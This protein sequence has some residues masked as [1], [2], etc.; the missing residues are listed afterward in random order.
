MKDNDVSNDSK[1][2]T[3]GVP[4]LKE[5]IPLALQH[6]MAMIVGNMVPAFL[7]ASIVGLSH[8][9][10][11]MLVQVSMLS[12]AIGTFIQLYPLPFIGSYKIGANLPVI[13]GM[14]YVF[15]GAALSITTEYGLPA[16]LGGQLVASILGIFIG[17]FVK[18]I[19]KYF[20]PLISGTIVTCMGIGLFPVAI[21]NLAGGL[22]SESYGEPINFAIG[23]FV[24]FV[25]VLINKFGTGLIKDI[26]ILIGILSGYI[27]CLCLGLINFSA[28]SSSAWLALPKPL[29]FGLEFRWEAIFILTLIFAIGIVEIMGG[30]TIVT[31]GAFN[32]EVTD[33][34]LSSAVIGVAAGSI[35]SSLLGALPVGIYSQNAA[36]VAMN[37]VVNKYVFAIAGIF[38]F[39]TGISPKMGALMA[40]VPSAVV[41]GAILVVFGMITMAG[42]MLL[43]MFGFDEETKIIAGV[44]ITLSIGIISA[45]Q[46]LE[47]FHPMIQTLIGGS[48]IVVGTIVAFLLQGIFGLIKSIKVKKNMEI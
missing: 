41:G 43:T 6:V 22:G 20:T 10:T 40:T 14:S 4:N 7:I 24:A 39:L 8:E 33:K 48:S 37:K 34:E 12:A 15:L 2:T 36:I 23:L 38:L 29:A 13:M 42:I 11:T 30:C 46:V 47:K 18:K 45:P 21:H 32:R 28:L 3:N 5:A 9:M 19:K 35:F 26:S 27:L 31:L 1:F 44:A 16:L 17:M 25:I